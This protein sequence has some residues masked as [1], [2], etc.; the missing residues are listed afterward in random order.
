MLKVINLKEGQNAEM[1]GILN[2]DL[3]LKYD[4]ITI[5]N[6]E[7]LFELMSRAKTREKNRIF[8]NR[9]SVEINRN[10]ALILVRVHI[11]VLGFDLTSKNLDVDVRG[12][13]NRSLDKANS[14]IRLANQRVSELKQ[15]IAQR[16]VKISHLQEENNRLR[17][18]IKSDAMRFS[19]FSDDAILG[20]PETASVQMIKK[21]YKKLSMVYHP[22]RGGNPHIMKLINVRFERLKLYKSS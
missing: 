6:K 19:D 11:G 20:V 2:D 15:L 21:N 9:I 18:D 14:I 10:G 13:E 5:N 22:D 1:S 16:D 8:S 4:G 3:L 12:S 7:D 17:G